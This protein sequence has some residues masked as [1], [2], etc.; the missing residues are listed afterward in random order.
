MDYHLNEL[1]YDF[2]STFINL[3][4]YFELEIEKTTA[5]LKERFPN[6]NITERINEKAGINELD[7]I[8]GFDSIPDY[9]SYSECQK[10]KVFEFLGMGLEILKRLSVMLKENFPNNRFRLIM[11]FSTVQEDVIYPGL[12]ACHVNC[13]KVWDSDYDYFTEMDEWYLEKDYTIGMLEITV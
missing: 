9:F 4:N 10:M 5:L 7:Y 8:I 1:D 13:Y 2:K 12:E 6:K 11:E 3:P